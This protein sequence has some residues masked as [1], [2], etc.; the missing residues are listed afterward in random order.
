MSSPSEYERAKPLTALFDEATLGHDEV[1]GRRAT[2]S[3]PLCRGGLWRWPF[4]GRIV[5]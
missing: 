2:S 5:A 3:Q 1:A 4:P